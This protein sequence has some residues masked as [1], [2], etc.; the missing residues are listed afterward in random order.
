MNPTNR[1]PLSLL[2]FALL[3]AGA[4]ACGTS[5]SPSSSPPPADTTSPSAGEVAAAKKH[6][7]APMT[8]SLTRVG[9]DVTPE[10]ATE[11]ALALT[12][13]PGHAQGPIDLSSTSVNVSFD[14][15]AGITLRD[16]EDATRP[17]RVGES[18]VVILRVAPGADVHD[19]HA[20]A[21]VRGDGFG[22][23]AHADYRFGRG[24]IDTQ[25]GAAPGLAKP[26]R[27]PRFGSFRSAGGLRASQVA[28]PS[29]P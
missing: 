11:H 20:R 13:H 19:V 14:L 7:G 24:L 9:Q 21:E 16:P 12:I 4:A 25:N 15:P 23:T 1:F 28:S 26:A 2:F 6:S 18:R 10:G 27:M 17:A 3:A 22:V 29:K 5:S 8:L